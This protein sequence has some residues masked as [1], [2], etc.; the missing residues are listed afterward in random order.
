MRIDAARWDADRKTFPSCVNEISKFRRV[1]HA[2]LATCIG[3]RNSMGGSTKY[4]SHRSCSR[5]SLSYRDRSIFDAANTA[6]RAPIYNIKRFAW[7]HRQNL[8]KTRS[9]A[10]RSR[11]LITWNSRSLSLLIEQERSR[12]S[13][14]RKSGLLTLSD[15]ACT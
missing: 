1:K 4:I 12:D 3:A 8:T 9:P 13:A 6:V 7:T 5:Q 2:D 11:F 15:T 10:R 14:R